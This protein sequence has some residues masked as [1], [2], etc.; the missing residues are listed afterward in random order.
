MLRGASH[1]HVEADTKIGRA[2]ALIREALKPVPRTTSEDYCRKL[3]KPLKPESWRGGYPS[4]AWRTAVRQV[5]AER[6]RWASWEA[7]PPETTAND[8]LF[9]EAR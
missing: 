6:S 5:L 7:K 4:K 8:P 3:V 9:Q 1:F 2:R